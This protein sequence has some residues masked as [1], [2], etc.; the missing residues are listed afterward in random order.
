[1][2]SHG[3]KIQYSTFTSNDYLTYTIQFENTGS[4]SAVNVR[5]EDV[6]DS[7]LDETSVKMIDASHGYTLNRSGNILKW[8]FAN[9]FLSPSVPDTSIGKGYI[10]F[11]VKPK[12]GYAVGDII[13]NAANIYFDFN[14]AIVT[15]TFNTEFVST[16]S[17]ANFESESFAVYPNPTNGLLTISSKNSSKSINN[18]VVSDVL[19]KTVQTNSFNSSKAVLDLSRLNSGVYFVKVQS[20]GVDKIMKVVKQ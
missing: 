18:V 14:P 9:I 8:N 7:K 17:V 3:G 11:Q 5:I 12:P 16:L 20:E 19:G 4:D 2:E 1:M 15:N 13:P 10:S 6:L